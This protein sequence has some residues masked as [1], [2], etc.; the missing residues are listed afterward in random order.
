[1]GPGAV[2]WGVGLWD[3]SWGCGMEPGAVGW[4][5]GLEELLLAGSAALGEADAP[6]PFPL[7][8]TGQFVARGDVGSCRQVKQ[9]LLVAH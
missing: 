5:V 2:G 3:G 8:G 1:M 9:S 4:G 6:W 7:W